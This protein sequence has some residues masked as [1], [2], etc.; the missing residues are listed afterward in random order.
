MVRFVPPSRIVFVRGSKGAVKSLL[1]RPNQLDRR[2]ESWRPPL[3]TPIRSWSD[4]LVAAA[5]RF[6]DLQAGS[7]WRD[8]SRVLPGCRGLILDVGCGSQPYR[9]LIPAAATYHGLD[10][11]GARTNFG[12]SMPETTYYEGDRWPIDETTADVVL[13]TET[14][15]HVPDPSVFLSE[16]FRCLKP[17]GRILLTVPFAAR[18]H[19]IPHDYWRFTPSGLQRLLGT[20]GFTDIAVYARGN[21]VTVACYKLMGLL[22]PLLFPQ[23]VS[24][25]KAFWLR[26]LGVLALPLICLLALAGNIS[27]RSR[28]GD[29]CIGYTAVASRPGAGKGN[30]S[31]S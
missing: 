10:Y 6:F 26:V 7:I 18:W 2:S 5:R 9:S 22:L 11:S 3:H 1:N 4:R 25:G 27:L 30:T 29:D 19:F 8:L 21:A 16:A 31:N 15:E 23:Q 14:L 17:R 24:R 12:Y 28:G 13:C 20:A